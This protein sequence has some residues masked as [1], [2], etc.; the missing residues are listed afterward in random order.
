M[1]TNSNQF[2]KKKF[3]LFPS[4]LLVCSS[5]LVGF[6]GKAFAVEVQAGPIWNN[7]D[8]RERCPRICEERGWRWTGHWRTTQRYR[9]SVC[10]CGEWRL[11]MRRAKLYPLNRVEERNFE[12]FRSAIEDRGL[13]PIHAAREV[14]DSNYTNL[15]L[16]LYEI[17]IS[18]RSRVFFFVDRTN[19]VVR[20]HQV[21]GHTR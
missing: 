2:M 1:S 13:D 8:A 11:D 9:M 14:G 4:L 5:A 16:N 7:D 18:G 21:G 20:I 6:S 3:L 17:R 15:G 12:I 19:R 10:S